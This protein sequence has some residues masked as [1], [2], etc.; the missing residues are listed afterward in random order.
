MHCNREAIAVYTECQR[1]L[2]VPLKI[3]GRRPAIFKIRFSKKLTYLKYALGQCFKE[4]P[5]K[6]CALMF[7]GVPLKIAGRSP[8]IFQIEFFKKGNLLQ[9]CP[10]LVLQTNMQCEIYNGPSSH[11]IS[12]KS[13]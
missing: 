11:H 10:W 6:F 7:L 8:A 4:T 12:T 9:I 5:S 1:F 13:H 2:G 3:A